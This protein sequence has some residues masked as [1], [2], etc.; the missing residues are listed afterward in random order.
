MVAKPCSALGGGETPSSVR[1]NR[2]LLS[3][4]SVRHH[5]FT[6]R[7]TTI[8]SRPRLLRRRCGLLTMWCVYFN[9]V[10]KSMRKRLR[11]KNRRAR[12]RWCYRD[13]VVEFCLQPSSLF[14]RDDGLSFINLLLS[15]FT[16]VPLG[17]GYSLRMFLSE[18]KHTLGSG[19][20][21]CHLWGN[22]PV[23]YPTECCVLP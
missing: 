14:K 15:R 13:A 5:P 4:P 11:V 8:G 22:S 18:E 21:Y 3:D 23:N 17:R 12:K 7:H 10:C 16:P 19:L 1:R 9:I 2:P 20:L 6:E